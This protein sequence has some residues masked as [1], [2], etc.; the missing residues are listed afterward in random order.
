MARG[1]L[2]DEEWTFFAPVAIR[3]G[4]RGGCS[5]VELR[6]VQDAIFWISRALCALRNRIERFINRLKTSRRVA[7][8]CDDTATSVLP[9]AAI[10]RGITFVDRQ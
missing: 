5:P 2:T 6:R 1:L 7:T 10:T 8:R 4:G 3:S 9:I